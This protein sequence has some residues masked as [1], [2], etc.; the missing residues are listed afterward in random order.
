MALLHI[1]KSLKPT[2]GYVER[3]RDLLDLSTR[4]HSIYGECVEGEGDSTNGSTV[5][6]QRSVFGPR[7]R[8]SQR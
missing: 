5:S 1:V 4:M 2:G 7:Q 3:M 8:D 6:V